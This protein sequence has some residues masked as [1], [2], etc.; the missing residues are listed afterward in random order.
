[1]LKG[2]ISSYSHDKKYGFIKSECGESYFFHFN[3]LKNKEDVPT[4]GQTVSFDDVPTPKGMAA[5]KISIDK[6]LE[7]IYLPPEKGKF[8]KSKSNDFG[9]NYEVVFKG[10]P[11]YS[12]SR[13]PDEAYNHMITQANVYGFNSLLH[14]QR[15]RRTGSEISNRGN[16]GGH[17]F[18]IHCYQ[19]TPALVQKVG[20]TSDSQKVIDS[21]RALEEKI[22]LLRAAKPKDLRHGGSGNAF[23]ILAWIAFIIFIIYEFF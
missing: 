17:K 8:F 19:S 15:T 3:D 6:D 7:K 20:Y 14:V 10:P 22:E 23:F 5:K 18:T 16:I 12:E 2:T 9:N 11:L 13:D 21:Y 1:M 4:S